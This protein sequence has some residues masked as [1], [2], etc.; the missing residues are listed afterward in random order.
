MTVL[1]R[2][3]MNVLGISEEKVT[4]SLSPENESAWDSLNAIV[5]ITEIEHA[6]DIRF[7]YDEAMSV[8]NFGDAKRLIAAKGKNPD[9]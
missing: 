4:D 1:T 7:G 8:K 9:A 6:F 5:L 3:F 2:V